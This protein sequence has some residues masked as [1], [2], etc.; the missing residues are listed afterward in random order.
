MAVES[1]DEKGRG[2]L[3]GVGAFLFYPRM[4]R[5]SY[6]IGTTEDQISASMVGR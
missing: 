5:D 4:D 2:L 6:H 1:P 3:E